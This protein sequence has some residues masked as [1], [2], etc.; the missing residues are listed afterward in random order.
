MILF[1]SKT[2]NTLSDQKIKTFKINVKYKVGVQ[3][4]KKDLNKMCYV[5]LLH[6]YLHQQQLVESQL[7]DIK[8]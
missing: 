3:I 4:L 6:T 5:K 8:E 7:V 2:S 1:I